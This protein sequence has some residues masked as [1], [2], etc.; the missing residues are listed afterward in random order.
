MYTLLLYMYIHRYLKH[1]YIYTH[2]YV[3]IGVYIYICK[4]A[5]KFVLTNVNTRM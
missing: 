4:N 1:I 3:Y 5:Y 2:V